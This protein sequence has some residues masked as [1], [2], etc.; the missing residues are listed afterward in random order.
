MTYLD[1][2]KESRSSEHFDLHYGF[3]DAVSA[4]A[5]GI[6]GIREEELARRCFEAIER[7]FGFL[8]GHPLSLPA[9][10]QKVPVYIFDVG[11][12]FPYGGS[13]FT[14]QDKHGDPFIGIPSR[15]DAPTRD[16]EYRHAAAA[17]CHEAFH[18][19]VWKLRPLR[20]LMSRPWRWFHEGCAVWTEM[21]VLPDNPEYLRFAMNWC[22]RPDLS[23]DD[24]RVLYESGFFV[25]Y[26]ANRFEPD[27]IAKIW[28][29]TH[30][31]NDTPFD[32]I[33]RLY[34]E[35]WDRLLPDY[36]RDA[37]FLTD[38]SSPAHSPDVV[39][40]YGGR[41]VQDVI[42][43]NFSAPVEG[44]LNHLACCYYLVHSATAPTLRL[45]EGEAPLLAE[46]TGVT[47][48][49]RRAAAPG[50]ASRWLVVVSNSG[51]QPDVHDGLRY[52]LEVVA[53]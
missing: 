51:L 28:L 32:V 52:K 12:I 43:P 11:A 35:R 29:S 20:D 48:D 15:N 14:F 7:A 1:F 24:D 42:E 4:R 23:L 9:P 39:A 41:A 22:D 33:R 47:S 3:R 31:P 6:H 16:E 8:L 40:R 53:T 26:L 13:P 27:M 49:G 46:L 50:D 5:A 10:R 21:H 2:L 19:A 38:P 18:A 37:F 30:N 44:H 45:T 34:P 17:A 25:R 36:F